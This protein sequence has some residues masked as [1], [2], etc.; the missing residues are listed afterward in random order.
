M[1]A[2]IAFFVTYTLWDFGACHLVSCIGRFVV[3]VFSL[4]RVRIPPEQIDRTDVIA[5][6]A[7]TVIF[8]FIVF[9]ITAA[10]LS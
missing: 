2:G 7:A 4:G 3:R 9:L 6:G 10:C 8:L 5:A 1:L